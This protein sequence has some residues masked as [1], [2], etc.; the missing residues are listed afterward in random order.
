MSLFEHLFLN[1]CGHSVMLTVSHK[2]LSNEIVIAVSLCPQ[3]SATNYVQS[4]V[5]CGRVKSFSVL[6]MYAALL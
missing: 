4:Y 5:N 2:A 1:F 6:R 3:P